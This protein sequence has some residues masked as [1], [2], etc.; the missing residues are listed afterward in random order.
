ME[1]VWTTTVAGLF[2]AFGTLATIWLKQRIQKRAK[3]VG[4]R[5][6]V[7]MHQMDAEAAFRDELR[8]DNAEF[9]VEL[10]DCRAECQALKGQVLKMGAVLTA[11]QDDLDDLHRKT[12]DQTPH[13]E[14]ARLLHSLIGRVRRGQR[15]GEA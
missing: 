5:A 4:D 1:P 2:G 11:I 13:D 9:R 14:I 15:V 12:V 8:A 10:K 7:R 6:D 3:M